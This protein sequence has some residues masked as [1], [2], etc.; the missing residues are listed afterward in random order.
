MRRATAADR[1]ASTQ[2]LRLDVAGNLCNGSHSHPMNPS[3]DPMNLDRKPDT[4]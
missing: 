1:G 2:P 3:A 4:A